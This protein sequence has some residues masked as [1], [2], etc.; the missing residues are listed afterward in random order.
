MIVTWFNNS[1][2]PVKKI[3]LPYKLTKENIAYTKSLSKLLYKKDFTRV[4]IK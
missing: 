3:L 4:E 1:V 2:T